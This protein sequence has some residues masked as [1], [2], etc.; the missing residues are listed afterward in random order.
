MIVSLLDSDVENPAGVSSTSNSITPPANQLILAFVEIYETGSDTSPPGISASGN[1]LTWV[2]IRNERFGEDSENRVA[3]FRAMGSSPSTG[4]VTFTHSDSSVG[5]VGWT[6]IAVSG[7]VTTG[8]NGSDAVRQSNSNGGV[9][10]V[11]MV[12]LAA[13]GDTDNAT[14][15][16]FA[17]VPGAPFTQG[18]GFTLVDDDAGRAVEWKESNDTAVDGTIPTAEEWVGIAIEVVAAAAFA[19]TMASS[20]TKLTASMTGAMT[21]AT[22]GTMASSL[23][24]LTGAFS[25]M[26]LTDAAGTM[27]SS[28][29]KLTGHVTGAQGT[30]GIM[31]STVSRLLS[32][33]VGAQSMTAVVAAQLSRL[34]FSGA[35]VHEAPPETPTPVPTG[36]GISFGF[37]RKPDN[38]PAGNRNRE[39]RG[40][41]NFP[42]GNRR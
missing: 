4:V 37:T 18:S 27:V 17:N 1:G 28:L 33:A 35:G 2:E 12:T 7:V 8:T 5:Y 10:D 41:P 23:A 9:D 25:G 3:L 29:S 30:G 6:I 13:F 39:Q 31:R 32:S 40:R 19:G 38:F 24:K 36:A 26:Q 14:F 15:G 34:L 20:A 11:L 22:T 42:P 16:F 21:A